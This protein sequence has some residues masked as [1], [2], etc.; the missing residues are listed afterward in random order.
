MTKPNVLLAIA[1]DLAWP[2]LSAYGSR[3]VSTPAADRVAREGALFTNCYTTAPTCTASRASLLTGRYPWRLEEGCQ[4]WGLLPQ[5]YA[6][7][8]DLLERSGYFIG[9]TYKGWGPGSI[10]ASGR[11]R[12]PAG[13]AFNR[14]TC[15]P[16]TSCMSKND[17]T[18]NFTD[19]LSRKPDRAPFCFWYGAKEPH[20]A[21]EPGSGL[22][23]GKRLEDAEVPSYLPDTP[24][25]RSDLLDYALEIERF[26]RDLG[27]MLQVLED[28]DELDNTI[29]IVTGDN[30][31]PFP[32][33]KANIYQNGCHVPL[34]IRWG[35]QMPPGRTI[36][37]FISFIDLAPTLLEAAGID[38]APL[39][40]DGRTFLGTLLS[41]AAGRVDPDRNF[42]QTGRERHGYCRPHNL[43][44]P[45]RSLVTD[46]LLYVRNFTPERPIRDCDASPTRALIES[47][48]ANPAMQPYY[49]LCFGP[50][51]DEELYLAADGP[52]CVRNVAAD[53]AYATLLHECRQ[54]LNTLLTSQE[55]P[56]ILSGGAIFECAPY[57]GRSISAYRTMDFP[58]I[59]P[60]H[61]QLANIPPATPT[62]PVNAIP[63][64]NQWS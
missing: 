3:M 26:D 49:D 2:H 8:P 50:R 24:E 17:Y 15:V 42:V 30:G 25:V 35:N 53:P 9:Y 28:R 1:D 43:G 23:H 63:P 61:Y 19:F 59:N 60:E 41:G 52:D 40:A 6:V 18:A 20:R 55:D 47:Y 38:S 29:V 45:M 37:D 48:K 34:A 11:A 36:T 13:P 27:A 54:R 39:Q 44:N 62:P 5:K 14:H 57:Y 46:D 21:Y 33:A 51:P 64:Y 32:R 58:P 12:N 10:Q 4:L 56:R 22:R 7:Y 31:L 16:L